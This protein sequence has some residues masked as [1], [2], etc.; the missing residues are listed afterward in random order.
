MERQRES[1]FSSFHSTI[2][3]L[4]QEKHKWFFTWDYVTKQIKSRFTPSWKWLW[5][6]KL[7]TFDYFHCV[8]SKFLI[9]FDEKRSKS[10]NLWSSYKNGALLVDRS[11]LTHKIIRTQMFSCRLRCTEIRCRRRVWCRRERSRNALRR[12]FHNFLQF[13]PHSGTLEHCRCKSCETSEK[14]AL[15]NENI[16]REGTG[17]GWHKSS[18]HDFPSLKLFTRN[19]FSIQFVNILKS[20]K[21]AQTYLK[22]LLTITV[23]NPQPR[24]WMLFWTNLL[25]ASMLCFHTKTFLRTSCID[26]FFHIFSLAERAEKSSEEFFRPESGLSRR[27]RARCKSKCCSH[28]SSLCVGAQYTASSAREVKRN[29]HINTNLQTITTQTVDE[30]VRQRDGDGGERKRVYTVY[31]GE[32]FVGCVGCV[33]CETEAIQWFPFQI[34]LHHDEW[35]KT[36]GFRGWIAR[37][38]GS[39]ARTIYRRIKMAFAI[40]GLPSRIGLLIGKGAVEIDLAESNGRM[41][42]FAPSQ[43]PWK[44]SEELVLVIL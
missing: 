42:M 29:P 17:R 10:S 4:N 27:M 40:I 18:V 2:I 20:S 3:F 26:R 37:V 9:K 41:S 21:K 24:C 11:T 16:E 15:L 23:K 34:N 14:H 6:P 30:G 13:L 19:Y 22:H 38:V 35:E 5:R 36:Q 44:S 43:Q 8:Y 32:M 31:G 1:G 25:E 33:L 7:H 39:H 12:S 28:R